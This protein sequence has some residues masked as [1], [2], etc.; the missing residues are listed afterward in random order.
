MASYQQYLPDLYNVLQ[1]FANE[2][3]VLG[4]ETE[5]V[6]DLGLEASQVGAAGSRVE[7][8]SVAFPE[9]GEGAQMLEGDAQQVAALLIEK[10]QREARVL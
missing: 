8:V 1:P 6:A 7:I 2:G 10:L 9:A 5:L 4:E 3:E